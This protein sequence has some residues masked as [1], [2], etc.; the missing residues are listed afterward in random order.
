MYK[1]QQVDQELSIAP[2]EL[3]VWCDAESVKDA[4]KMLWAVLWSIFAEPAKICIWA[5]TDCIKA[6]IC[7]T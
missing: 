4:H 6:Y 7:D 5:V 2:R 3:K 1:K